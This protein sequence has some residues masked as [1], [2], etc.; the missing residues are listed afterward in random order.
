[1]WKYGTMY[2]AEVQHFVFKVSCEIL[3]V[4]SCQYLILYI[5]QLQNGCKCFG[6]YCCGLEPYTQATDD[7]IHCNTEY[8]VSECIVCVLLSCILLWHRIMLEIPFLVF[9]LLTPKLSR[10]LH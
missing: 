3:V 8:V 5:C 6:N 10:D 9:S 2:C 4:F 7:A 1:M